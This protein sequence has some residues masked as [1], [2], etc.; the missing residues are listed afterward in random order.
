MISFFSPVWLPQG[1]F[2]WFICCVHEGVRFFMIHCLMLCSVHVSKGLWS[3][4][5]C[6][7]PEPTSIQHLCGYEKDK[8]STERTRAEERTRQTVERYSRGGANSPTI[9]PCTDILLSLPFTLH[10]LRGSSQVFQA[11]PNWCLETKR[12]YIRKVTKNSHWA[13]VSLLCKKCHCL[14]VRFRYT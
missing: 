14:T 8:D 6:R 11:Q 5:V 12:L 9:V 2:L 3:D 4:W 7:K 1:P 13:L 10:H